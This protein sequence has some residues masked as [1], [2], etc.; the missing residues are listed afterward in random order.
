VVTITHSPSQVT[1]LDEVIFTAQAKDDSGIARILIFVNQEQV[2]ECTS[3][4]ERTDAKGRKYWECIYTGGPYDEET[5]TYRAEAIDGY[6]NRGFSSEESVDV[7]LAIV[8]P[9]PIFQPCLYHITG[10]IMDFPYPPE[11]LKIELCEA[12]QI[13]LSPELGGATSFVCKPGGVVKESALLSHNTHEFQG[14]CPGTYKVNPIIQPGGDICQP[15]G[16]FWNQELTWGGPRIVNVPEEDTADFVFVPRETSLP[17]VDISFSPENPTTE[18]EIQLIVSASDVSGIGRIS[19]EGQIDKVR[20]LRGRCRTERYEGHEVEICEEEEY[21][22]T[23]TISQQCDSSPCIYTIPRIE[24]D[25]ERYELSLSVMVWDRICNKIVLEQSLEI[26]KPTLLFP[27]RNVRNISAYRTS[28]TFMVSDRDWRT[29]LSLVPIAYGRQ[30]PED[31][32]SRYANWWP[33]GIYEM[34]S[35]PQVIKYPLLIF[36]QE[37][38]G[39]PYYSSFDIDSAVH[40]MDKYPTRHLTVFVGN[41]TI[42]HR[43]DDLLYYWL[44]EVGNFPWSTYTGWYSTSPR[45]EIRFFDASDISEVYNHYFS[46]I[47]SVIVCQDDYKAALLASVFAAAINTPLYFDGHF[48]LEDI[49]DKVVHIVGDVR[50]ETRTLIQGAAKELG[51]FVKGTEVIESPYSLEDIK[52]RGVKSILVNPYDLDTSYSGTIRPRTER[53]FEV[54]TFGNNSLAA[55]ILAAATHRNIYFSPYD[56]MFTDDSA[57][58]SSPTHDQLKSII[59]DI[60]IEYHAPTGMVI[61]ASPA[62]I[63]DSYYTGCVDDAW[64]TRHEVDREYG[65]LG[66]IYGLTVTDTSAYIARDIFYHDIMGTQDVIPGLIISHT[67]AA[68]ISD[69]ESIFDDLSDSP[70]YDVT[71]Y[72]P[73]YSWETDPPA[74]EYLGK[75]FII[76][77]DHGGPSSWCDTLESGEIPGIENDRN[78]RL[79]VVFGEACLTNNFWQGGAGTMGPNWIRRGAIAYFGAVGVSQYWECGVGSWTSNPRRWMSEILEEENGEWRAKSLG[80]LSDSLAHCHSACCGPFGHCWVTDCDYRNK[81]ILLGDPWLSPNF[82]PED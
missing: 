67:I 15:E 1:T 34:C 44:V 69:A 72:I 77:A 59:D 25:F 43:L 62:H 6:N 32:Y 42:N 7:S 18:D 82:L 27:R 16:M 20:I 21:K 75:N 50:P 41:E 64:Q 28:E 55:P 74:T 38:D 9:P 8:T 48:A 81:F 56:G 40:F 80:A 63:P 76:F 37:A 35:E 11:M 60:K 36:H 79:P 49:E 45:A 19:I 68:E 30:C 23:E 39:A 65:A 53:S 52:F 22:V 31:E 2:K 46:E 26:Y 61:V 4:S 3:G 66:R 29:V 24:A 47:N 57:C 17:E 13:T 58:G 5:L 14:L 10:K 70:N 51:S 12:E 54:R 73:G 71:G 78:L 33:A